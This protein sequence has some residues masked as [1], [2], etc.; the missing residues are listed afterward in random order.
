MGCFRFNMKKFFIALNVMLFL[1]GLTALIIGSEEIYNYKETSWLSKEAYGCL[2]GA[3]L[4]TVIIT[5]VA[6]CEVRKDDHLAPNK[7]F[8]Y[9]CVMCTILLLNVISFYYFRLFFGGLETSGDISDV[10]KIEVAKEL[11]DSVLS[12]YT[13]CCTGCDE[14]EISLQC[15][16]KQPDVTPF[17]EASALEKVTSP[18]LICE[19]AAPCLGTE[20]NKGLGLGCYAA[21]SA[22]PSY[23]IGADAC[24]VIAEINVD[25]KPLVGDPNNGFSCGGGDPKEYLDNVF[26]YLDSV[27]QKTVI[28]WGFFMTFLLMCMIS[29]TIILIFPQIRDY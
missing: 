8:C 28:A 21:S 23:P 2:L 4:I 26:G 19:Y 17:C 22:I 18:S 7:L 24:K 10:V 9:W 3:G 29:S 14:S 1:M 27:Y 16:D 5:I 11:Q 13:V 25:D 20:E 15:A 6:I 12:S